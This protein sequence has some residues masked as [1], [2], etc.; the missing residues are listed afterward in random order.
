MSVTDAAPYTPQ[1]EPDGPEAS[2][3]PESPP[4]AILERLVALTDASMEALFDFWA[5]ERRNAA[6]AYLGTVMN[7][8]P[9]MAHPAGPKVDP[10]DLGSRLHA[11]LLDDLRTVAP[12]LDMPD[13]IGR[14][15]DLKAVENYGEAHVRLELCDCLALGEPW[16]RVAEMAEAVHFCRRRDE[17]AKIAKHLLGVCHSPDEV[18]KC[19][20]RLREVR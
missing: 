8:R 4:A 1:F 15:R 14:M 13:T 17:R 7:W 6:R 20:Q 18:D 2:W 9:G 5:E 12:C 16:E 11:L 19:I 10:S 3:L